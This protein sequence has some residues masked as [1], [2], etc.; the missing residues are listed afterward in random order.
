MIITVVLIRLFHD[1]YQLDHDGIKKSTGEYV[2]PAVIAAT[3]VC[4]VQFLCLKSIG[5]VALFSGLDLNSSYTTKLRN[6]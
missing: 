3:V 6:A 5:S 4:Y 2:S 1:V